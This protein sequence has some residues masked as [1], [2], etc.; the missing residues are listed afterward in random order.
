MHVSERVA[1]AHSNIATSSPRTTPLP[2]SAMGV[3]DVSRGTPPGSREKADRKGLMGDE[4]EQVSISREVHAETVHVKHQRSRSPER[5]TVTQRDQYPS[6]IESSVVK[7]QRSSSPNPSAAHTYAVKEEEG[8]PPKRI[9]SA[10]ARSPPIQAVKLEIEIEHDLLRGDVW[11]DIGSTGLSFATKEDPAGGA[12]RPAKTES[13]WVEEAI[14][15][16]GDDDSTNDEHELDRLLSLPEGN[17]TYKEPGTENVADVA[18]DWLLDPAVASHSGM[19]V[20]VQGSLP[21]RTSN[22]WHNGAYEDAQA[23]VLSVFNTG[24]GNMAFASTARVRFLKPLNPTVDTFVVP[25]EF[26]VPVKPD[27]VD[28]E[29]LIIGGE[30]TGYLAKLRE[31]VSQGWYF[32]SAAYDHF[33]IKAANLCRVLPTDD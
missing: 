17:Q 23:V 26:L 9:R 13:D 31:E 18:E 11:D 6:R 2:A 8:N 19:L 7:R 5:S 30:Y 21:T 32:V 14:E 27:S 22:G 25:V 4:T 1:L 24:R 28:Q 20:I 16:P 15:V 12:S 29:A 33:E 3:D 10:L